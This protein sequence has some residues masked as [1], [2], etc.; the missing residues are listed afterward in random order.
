MSTVPLALRRCSP[1]RPRDPD[2]S[3]R[4]A[5]SARTARSRSRR[6]GVMRRS[7]TALTLTG[8]RLARAPCA[9]VT[10]PSCC[11]RIVPSSSNDRARPMDRGGIHAVEPQFGLPARRGAEACREHATRASAYQLDDQPAGGQA[12]AREHEIGLGLRAPAACPRRC[13]AASVL[14]ICTAPVR[15]SMV[16]PGCRSARNTQTRDRQPFAPCAQVD[17][18]DVG[19]QRLERRLVEAADPRAGVAACLPAAHVG[20]QCEIE[21]RALGPPARPHGLRLQCRAGVAPC[22]QRKR[23]AAA[24]P[25]GDRHGLPGEVEAA[26]ED[27]VALRPQREGGVERACRQLHAHRRPSR[28]SPTF[29]RPVDTATGEAIDSGGPAGALPGRTWTST[30]AAD[31]D[32][33]STRSGCRL[34]PS[35]RARKSTISTEVSPTSMRNR[36]NPNSRVRAPCA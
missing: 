1:F 13:G 10:A 24:Q 4:P 14:T 21:Q 17:A 29:S 22:R 35:S 18:L 12:L 3:A 9:R 30:R 2:T 16:D 6:S 7:R 36:S 34:P 23:L 5:P 25:P 28:S 31:S 19:V 26:I 8:P 20:H 15:R 27:L 33:K 32:W 11:A